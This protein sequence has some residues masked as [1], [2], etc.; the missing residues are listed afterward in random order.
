[1]SDLLAR[2][3]RVLRSPDDLV[4]DDPEQLRQNAA[5]L[6][7]VTLVGAAAW[8]LVV[9]SYTGG[10]QLLWAPIKAPLIF[11][12]PLGVC[13]PALRAL[14]ADDPADLPAPRLASATLAG[15]ARA[16]VLCAATAPLL[17]LLYG[18]PLGYEGSLLWTVALAAPPTAAGLSVVTRALDPSTQRLGAQLAGLT[19]LAVVTLQTSWM[20]RPFLA[21]PY[22]E[23]TFLRPVEDDAFTSLAGAM[24]GCEAGSSTCAGLRRGQPAGVLG[25]GAP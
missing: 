22:R 6:V 8:G 4:S 15:A 3:D 14:L 2:F 20:L 25:R 7:L 19:L 13:L 12:L 17:W 10:M 5:D 1:M 23:V 16:A 18:L 24:A 9:G 21:H 11:L